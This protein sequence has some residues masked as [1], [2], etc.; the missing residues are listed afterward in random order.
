LRQFQVEKFSEAAI[1][2]FAVLA[3]LSGLSNLCQRQHDEFNA[4]A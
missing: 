3:K 4:I 1:P 2:G